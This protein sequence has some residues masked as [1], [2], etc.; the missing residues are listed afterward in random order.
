MS[1]WPQWEIDE[2]EL[3]PRVVRWMEDEALGFGALFD[4]SA[5]LYFEGARPKHLRKMRLR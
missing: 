5:R 4:E 3:G 2:I 1:I